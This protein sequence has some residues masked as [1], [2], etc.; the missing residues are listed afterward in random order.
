MRSRAA[1]KGAI[2]VAFNGVT[3]QKTHENA[4]RLAVAAQAGKIP[5]E[6]FKEFMKSEMANAIWTPGVPAKVQWT[7]GLD[8]KT[9]QI[10][11][12]S[13]PAW[14]LMDMDDVLTVIYH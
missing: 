9:F 7:I 1:F 11:H 4:C 5:E 12:L 8:R 14:A 2:V 13:S 6:E 3:N 10:N